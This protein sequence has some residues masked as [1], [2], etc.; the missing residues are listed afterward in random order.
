MP[1]LRRV[2]ATALVYRSSLSTDPKK[3]TGP[4]GSSGTIVSHRRMQLLDKSFLSNI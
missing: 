3:Q 2:P 4:F 1:L